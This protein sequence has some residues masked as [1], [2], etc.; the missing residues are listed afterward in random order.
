MNTKKELTDWLVG[1]VITIVVIFVTSTI[2]GVLLYLYQS[3]Q[4]NYRDG[5]WGSWAESLVGFGLSWFVAMQIVNAI[6]PGT[7]DEG[8][9]PS[10]PHGDN[11]GT[12]GSKEPSASGGVPRGQGVSKVE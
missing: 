4:G 5:S 3:S 2:G 1:W 10:D 12:N 7:T 11:P 8:T 6:Y 9:A